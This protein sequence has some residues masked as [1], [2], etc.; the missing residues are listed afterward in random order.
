MIRIEA[1]PV[2]AKE[3]MASLKMTRGRRMP[4]SARRQ[5][6]PPVAA[7]EKTTK[8]M[9]QRPMTATPTVA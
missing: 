8:I 6:H 3:I 1:V 5:E 4:R 2:L 7:T 9:R